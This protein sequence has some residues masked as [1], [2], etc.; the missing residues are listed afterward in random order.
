MTLLTVEHVSEGKIKHIGLSSVSSATLRRAAKIAPIAAVQ[1]EYSV[2]SRDIEGDAGTNLLATCRE[3]GVAVVVACPLGRG[4]LTSTFSQGK[5]VGDSKDMRPKSMPRFQEGNRQANVELVAQF[6]AFADR[7]GCT[8]SQL[9]LAWLLKQGDDIF[10]IPGTKKIKYLE[11][12]WGALQ[13]RL[14]DEEEE[15]IRAFAEKAE[16]AGGTVPEAFAH[17]L[18]RDTKEEGI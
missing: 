9:A 17:Y 5:D 18:F 15:D 6:K 10:P 7:K 4:L 2:F 13:I 12:N 1:T 14:T 3:L 16:L 11:E 8:V